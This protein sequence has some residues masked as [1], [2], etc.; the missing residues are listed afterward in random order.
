MEP[1]D[2]KKEN[3][4]KEP[5]KPVLPDIPAEPTQEEQAAAA[6]MDKKTQDVLASRGVNPDGSPI[7]KQEIQQEPLAVQQQEEIITPKET[8]PP[9]AENEPAQ[10][11]NGIRR[12]F[13]K[14]GNAIKK[15][16]I[17]LANLFKKKD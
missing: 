12:F 14:V 10:Q 8:I 4:E 1:L 3:T 5:P 11:P 15:P 17:W 13:T 16:F 2:K 6:E 7:N 9:I